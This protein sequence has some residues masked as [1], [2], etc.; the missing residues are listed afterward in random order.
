MSDGTETCE[1][2]W[3]EAE[4]YFKSQSQSQE[5]LSPKIERV[6]IANSIVNEYT[7]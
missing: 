3:G 5:V 1:T 6:L 7:D 2:A 4:C